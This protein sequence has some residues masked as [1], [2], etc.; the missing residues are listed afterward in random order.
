MRFLDASGFFA[1]I[2]QL[3]VGLPARCA[4]ASSEQRD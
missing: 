1:R 2:D 3:D 4:A